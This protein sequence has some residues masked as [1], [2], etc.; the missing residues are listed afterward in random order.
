MIGKY[1]I[2][3]TYFLSMLA[4]A[5]CL[6]TGQARSQTVDQE[7]L[8]E[9]DKVD[10]A[11]LEAIARELQ[12]DLRLTITF[13]QQFDNPTAEELLGVV[14]QKTG[15]VLTLDKKLRLEGTCV[16]AASWQKMCRPGRSWRT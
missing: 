9:L 13:D 8:R 12:A 3:G 7:T 1:M 2:R 14:Q 5:W 6:R 15:V 11:K 4:L 16:S 10:E